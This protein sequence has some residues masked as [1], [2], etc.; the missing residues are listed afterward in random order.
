VSCLLQAQLFDV[1][2]KFYLN[3]V[4]KSITPEGKVRE[5]LVEATIDAKNI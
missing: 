2:S 1:G 5:Q 3:E 4:H